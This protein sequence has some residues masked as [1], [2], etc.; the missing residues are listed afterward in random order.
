V[1]QRLGTWI[2]SDR[3]VNAQDLYGAIG[4]V[5]IALFW[6]NLLARSLVLAN[7]FAVVSQRRLYPRRIAQP[8]LSDADKEV[9]VALAHNERRRPEQTITVTFTDP[10]DEVETEGPEEPTDERADDPGDEPAGQPIDEQIDQ[11]V[12]QS[13]EEHAE[14]VMER[15]TLAAHDGDDR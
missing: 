7:E 3:L 8:P 15:P 1:L 4:L 11:S 13:A 2:I 10:D 12:V 9:L 14:E 6:I 5:V